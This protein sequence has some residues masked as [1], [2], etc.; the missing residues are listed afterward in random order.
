MESM[1]VVYDSKCGL[2]SGISKWILRQPAYVYLRFVASESREAERL[3]PGLPPGELAVISDA[4]EVWIGEHAWILCL[5]AL[6]EYRGWAMRLSRPALLPLARQAFITLSRNRRAI[7]G[8]LGLQG[9]A[10][11]REHLLEVPVPPCEIK[12]R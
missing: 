12:P 1:L 8:L 4:G 10:G 6:R 2:C 7:S 9:D 11:I 3:C 5:W